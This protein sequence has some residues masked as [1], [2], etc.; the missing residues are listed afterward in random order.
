MV[1]FNR[2]YNRSPK[3]GCPGHNNAL[4]KKKKQKKTNTCYVRRVKVH[5]VTKQNFPTCHNINVNRKLRIH[6]IRCDYFQTINTFG[7]NQVASV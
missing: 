1:E 2:N 6:V 5:I 3:Q 7:F 4:D